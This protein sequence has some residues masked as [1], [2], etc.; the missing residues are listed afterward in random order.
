MK[1]AKKALALFLSALV[2]ILCA[3][4]AFAADPEACSHEWTWVIDVAPSCGDGV[5]HAVCVKCGAVDAEGTVIYGTGN[6]NWEWVVDTPAGA[7]TQGSKHQ[8]C[9]ECGAVQNLNTIIR[10]RFS[11]RGLDN[12]F[13]EAIDNIVAA[14]NNMIAQLKTI[15]KPVA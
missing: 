5:K 1:S 4:P 14:I 6:H 3:V 11:N 7:L 12:V 13:L 9:T 15:F 2:V 8:V 10:S